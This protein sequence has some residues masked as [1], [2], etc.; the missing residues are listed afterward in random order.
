MVEMAIFNIYYVQKVATPKV[1][2]P[3]LQFLCSAHPLM[4]FNICK[5][6]HEISQMHFYLQ[7]RHKYMVEM[8]MFNVQRAIKSRQT[9]VTVNMLYTSSYGGL[10]CEVSSKY[11]KWFSTYRVDT[12]T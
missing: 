9:R 6:Y 8:A 7:S 3:E 1:G 10:M 12:S 2:S 5:K 4:V 11:L